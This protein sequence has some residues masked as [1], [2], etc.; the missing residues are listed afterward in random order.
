MYN[1]QGFPFP[2]AQNEV[3]TQGYA[4]LGMHIWSVFLMRL[5]PCC[6]EGEQALAE[7]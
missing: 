5:L 2:I 1:S 3:K 6:F 4:Q 7:K